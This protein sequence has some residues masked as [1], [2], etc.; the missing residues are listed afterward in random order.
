MVTLGLIILFGCTGYVLIKLWIKAVN[1]I[2]GHKPKGKNPYIDAHRRKFKNDKDYNDYIEWLN[3]EKRRDI[4]FE[5]VKTNRDAE[6][7]KS[8]KD[9]IK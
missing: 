9:T 6:F 2:F 8:F 4:P 3:Y 7:E 5:K 1:W